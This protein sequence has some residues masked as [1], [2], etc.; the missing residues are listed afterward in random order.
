MRGEGSGGP[1]PRRCRPTICDEAVRRLSTVTTWGSSSTS[2]RSAAGL[3]Q[4]ALEVTGC[5]RRLLCG[6]GRGAGREQVRR[7]RRAV[8]SP[9]GGR[10]RARRL[11]RRRVSS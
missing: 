7:E 8:P 2:G 9:G 4:R 3:V 1:S 10:A 11:A 5:W 6:R